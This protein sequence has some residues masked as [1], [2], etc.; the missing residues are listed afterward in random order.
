VAIENEKH[1]KYIVEL[2]PGRSIYSKSGLLQIPVSGEKNL[3]GANF[4]PGWSYLS[5]PF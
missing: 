5:T 2:K 3:N 1:G 4:T